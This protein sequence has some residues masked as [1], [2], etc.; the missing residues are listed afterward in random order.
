MAS[1]QPLVLFADDHADTL[2]MYSSFFIANGFRTATAANGLAALDLARQLRPAIIVLDIHMP[3]LNGIGALKLMRQH[4]PL[5]H[6]PMLML[7]AYDF[8]E[9]DALAAGA[10]A[11]CVKP[12]TPDKL[13]AE[14]RT[15]LYQA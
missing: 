3:T 5:Q 11:V 15:L 7:T 10:T 4:P 6:T 2:D 14:I 13:L 1:K 9:E 12:C 8:N